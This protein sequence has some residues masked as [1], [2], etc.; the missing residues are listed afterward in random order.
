LFIVSSVFTGSRAP[1]AVLGL[2]GF[3]LLLLNG[4][5]SRGMLVRWIAW[6]TLVITVTGGVAVVYS[7]P[8]KTLSDASEGRWDF[9]YVA[10]Q[11]FSERPLIGYGY[12]S[13][14][15]DLVSRVPGF[16]RWRGFQT[17][18]GGY[19]NEY[20]TALAEQGLIGFVALAVLFGFLIK[21]GWQL[22][23]HKWCSWR[24]KQWALF[25]V[26]FLVIR[27]G[28][29][30]GGLFGYNREPADFLGFIFLALVVSRFSV[31]EDRARYLT[32]PTVFTTA[33]TRGELLAV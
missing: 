11:K 13:F 17:H 1:L 21:C 5:R 31:E 10:V 23:F 24:N 6:V 4:I 18:P 15:D 8:F 7:L 2:S 22:A 26:I 28:V 12:E 32:K 19:H 14:Q 29:E 25:C 30:N 20:L 3:A 16:Y 27:A 33:P 9:W